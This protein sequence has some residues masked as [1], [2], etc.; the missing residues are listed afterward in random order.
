MTTVKELG[1]EP[2]LKE[3]EEETLCSICCEALTVKNIVNPECGHA[4]CKECFWRWAK[5]KN[6]CPFCRTSLLKNDE[7]AQDIQQM[8]QLLEHRTRIVRQV[9]EAYD[10]EENLKQK[11]NRLTRRCRNAE[12]RFCNTLSLIKGQKEILEK[13]K[14]ANGGTYQTFK[15]FKGKIVEICVKDRH[16]REKIDEASM[17]LAHGDNG[18]CMEVLRDIKCL[19]EDKHPAVWSGT[20]PL[21]SIYR[22]LE[23]NRVRKERRKFREKLKWRDDWYIGDHGLRNLFQG[24]DEDTDS[25][26]MPELEENSDSD[27]G[28]DMDIDHIANLILTPPSRG[29]RLSE[30]PVITRGG[31]RITGHNHIGRARRQLDY[32]TVLHNFI[33]ENSI[34]FDNNLRPNTNMQLNSARDYTDAAQ[35]EII[36]AR[37]QH[38]RDRFEDQ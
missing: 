17:N 10:E 30:P 23:M 13:L 22:V 5:D 8:R 6:S 21:C 16:K 12:E 18:M 7:E 27:S 37:A 11:A 28:S 31:L 24:N 34:D 36:A 2:T 29:F 1:L 32:H 33:A 4:T 14:Q 9:E 25:D 3:E 19:R 38:N 26:S 20:H 15:Y 35:Q